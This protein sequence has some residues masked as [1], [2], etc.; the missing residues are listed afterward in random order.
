MVAGAGG[1][2]ACAAAAGTGEGAGAIGTR[3]GRA[4]VVLSG[5][6]DCMSEGGEGGCDAGCTSAR[7][8]GMGVATMFIEVA[9]A[10]AEDD[11]M[12]KAAGGGGDTAS[13]GDGPAEGRDGDA[14]F[15]EPAASWAMPMAIIDMSDGVGEGPPTAES[16]EE[17][18]ETL[19]VGEARAE[20]ARCGRKLWCVM[21]VMSDR[22]GGVS[23]V[24]GGG[25]GNTIESVTAVPVCGSVESS[26]TPLY[27]RTH[28]Y[29]SAGTQAQ[30]RGR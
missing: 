11:A 5:E 28:T 30:E 16:D 22:G 9:A 19:F 6:A 17:T 10:V 29:A 21:A 25:H 4:A 1:D 24:P 12:A 13:S 2:C 15:P 14:R 3:T 7:L 26:I 8:G 18:E 23:E 20:P 27:S